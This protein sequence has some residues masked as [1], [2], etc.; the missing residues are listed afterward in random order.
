MDK[1]C[2]SEII[3]IEHLLS[4]KLQPLDSIQLNQP[5]QLEAEKDE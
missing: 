5:E 3:L 2:K 1:V 4:D